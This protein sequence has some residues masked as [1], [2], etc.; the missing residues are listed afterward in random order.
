[1]RLGDVF[2]RTMRAMTVVDYLWVAF[3]VLFVVGGAW[4]SRCGSQ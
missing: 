2:R 1:M 4:L 3:V